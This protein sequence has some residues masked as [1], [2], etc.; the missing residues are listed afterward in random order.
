MEGAASDGMPADGMTGEGGGEFSDE[1]MQVMEILEQQG[2]SLDEI[3]DAAETVLAEQDAGI[4]P[5][6]GAV[7]DEEA[8]K[9]GHYKFA[10]F[11][12]RPRNKTAEQEQRAA[13]ARRAMRDQI[14]GPGVKDFS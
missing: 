3:I 8:E 13:R 11:I 10:S 7:A 9:T 5:A 1:L 6:A 14:K 2:F 12:G 4:D